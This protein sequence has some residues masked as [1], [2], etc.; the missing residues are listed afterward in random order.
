MKH[1]YIHPESIVMDC[2]SSVTI[3][4]GSTESTTIHN[5]GTGGDDGYGGYDPGNSLTR[6]KNGMW[7]SAW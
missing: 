2:T 3:L 7:D 1:T 6:E 4:A 5:G